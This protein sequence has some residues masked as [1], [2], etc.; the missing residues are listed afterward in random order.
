V[1]KEVRVQIVA[2]KLKKVELRVRLL[3]RTRKISVIL[4]RKRRLKFL[5]KT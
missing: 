5:L 3:P 1:K 4:V 2:L